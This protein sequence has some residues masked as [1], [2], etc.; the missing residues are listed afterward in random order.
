MLSEFM[1]QIIKDGVRHKCS[2]RPRLRRRKSIR[3]STPVRMRRKG[4]WILSNVA[5][6]L[7]KPAFSF[8][9]EASSVRPV[10]GFTMIPILAVIAAVIATIIIVAVVIVIVIRSKGRGGEDKRLPKNSGGFNPNPD[11]DVCAV[12]LKKSMESDILDSDDKNP[13]VVPHSSG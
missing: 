5:L 11:H 13:D 1:R 4:F 2:K 10:F 9:S 12:P 7:V 6:S 3:A 8:L